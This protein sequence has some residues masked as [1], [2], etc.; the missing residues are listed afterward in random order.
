MRRPHFPT[1]TALPVVRVPC[2]G[3]GKLWDRLASSSAPS[4]CL[5]CAPSP[6]LLPKEST[7]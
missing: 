6:T 4:W 5:T 3:C 2:P 7:R 1:S